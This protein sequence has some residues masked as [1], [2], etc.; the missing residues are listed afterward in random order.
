MI[1]SQT[2]RILNY[3]VVIEV[4]K[5]ASIS[6]KE[7]I[8]IYA[9]GNKIKRGI[10]RSLPL[11]RN[12][13]GVPIRTFYK[14]KRVLKNGAIEPHYVYKNKEKNKLILRT[15]TKDI[16]LPSGIYEYS[17][18]YEV[19][20]QIS[21]YKGFDEIYWNAIGTDVIFPIEKSSCQVILP[22]G[23][24]PKKTTCYSDPFGSE[25][26]NCHINVTDNELL[27]TPEVDLKIKEGLTIAASFQKEV[28]SPPSSLY[29]LKYALEE[30]LV[31]FVY[32]LSINP[33]IQWLFFY[34]LLFNAFLFYQWNKS[35]KDSTKPTIYPLFVTPKGLSPAAINYFWKENYSLK[36]F[37]ASIIQLII[38]GYL[39]ITPNPK[40][41]RTPART[42]YLEIQ[43][44]ADLSI[45][46]EEKKILK[47]LFSGSK[48]YL[49]NRKFSRPLLEAKSAHLT[50]LDKQF[51]KQIIAGNNRPLINVPILVSLTFILYMFF[52]I[53]P[54]GYALNN[55]VRYVIIIVGLSGL[56]ILLFLKKNTKT[57]EKYSYKKNIGLLIFGVLLLP[58]LLICID[59][60]YR[61][62]W[63]SNEL[64]LL[65]LLY[66]TVL[67]TFS[68]LIFQQLIKQPTT[69]KLKL[70]SEIAGLKMYLEMA[71][72]DRLNLLN[73]PNQTPQHFE[74]MLP[75]AYALGIE[76]KWS[77]HFKN[78]LK[79]G[80]EMPSTSSH[81]MIYEGY[82]FSYN[83]QNNIKSALTPPPSPST[84]RHSSYR[85][86]SSSSSSSSGSSGGGYS[87][88][89]GGGGGVG[90]W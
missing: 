29:K 50:S 67:I 15:G 22:T 71:E 27:F 48:K 56:A 36:A 10:T 33:L 13:S 63:R 46:D 41:N 76:H 45:A 38:K 17:I 39:K 55:I 44:N 30:S 57:N 1:F 31:L 64:R 49:V 68:L 20:N 21:Y 16:F 84:S 42:F 82:D 83:F 74:E 51:K 62:D 8:Q 87:G 59:Y 53:G 81:S 54:D 86:S 2:E 79:D 18:E 40:D 34:L 72:K 4:K 58:I 25:S 85:S 80:I 35:G 11:Y 88:G 23:A 6:V 28:V 61:W 43:D 65:I 78:I 75:F 26:Q 90:G 70:Q 66:I 69:S 3:D 9:D 19:P 77:S 24:I 89:G 14:I 37:T 52:F 73:P 32:W 60:D 47:E 12:L 5:D 7:K